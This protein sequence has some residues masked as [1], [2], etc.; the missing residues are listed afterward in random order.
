MKRDIFLRKSDL[1][2]YIASAALCAGLPLA[3]ISWMNLCTQECA[4]GH[5]YRLFGYPF[6]LVGMLF[7]ALIAALHFCSVK[8]PLC[9]IAAGW[10]LAAGLGAEL[11]FIYVQKYKI[12]S[13]CP[14]CLSITAALLIAS[15]A[16]V[17]GFYQKMRHSAIR[18][19]GGQQMMHSFYSKSYKVALFFSLGF[20]LA[21]LGTSKIDQLQAAENDVK[22]SLVF[23]N[24]A[25][26]LE[27][28]IFTDWRCMGCRSLDPVFE[29]VASKLGS[30]AKIMF[31]DYAVHP[32]SLNFTPYNI[33]F[34]MHNK[35]NY[36]A[37][38]RALG[39]LSQQTRAPTDQQVAA[40]AARLGV[41]YQQANY[42]DI[43]LGM[44]YF[45]HLVKQLRVEGTPTVIVYNQTSKKSKKLEGVEDI[46]EASIFN[47]IH[48]TQ[49]AHR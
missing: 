26:P 10:L 34:M 35:P 19:E 15:A 4:G 43:A 30:Q 22:E 24:R 3:I 14:I 32:D 6:E 20:V 16:Y 33:S 5:A 25:S 47:A 46:S 23:G 45:N 11:Y 39:Q 13:W 44:K 7:F 42:A 28:Y 38:R 49:I 31:V 40:L 12:G 9:R 17:Y 36:F 1:P 41:R 48:S 18:E 29:S 2:F 8:Q 21:F 37:L 27:L